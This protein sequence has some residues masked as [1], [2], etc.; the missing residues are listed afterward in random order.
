MKKNHLNLSGPGGNWKKKI[1]RP[2]PG[3]H[4]IFSSGTGR[5]REENLTYTSGWAGHRLEFFSLLRAGPGRD[6]GPVG[7]G[8]KKSGLYRLL[9][10][11]IN[12]HKFQDI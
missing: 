12:M 4:F 5:A 1:T 6:C 3:Q 8:P 10:G 11:M 9:S 2:G 7:P